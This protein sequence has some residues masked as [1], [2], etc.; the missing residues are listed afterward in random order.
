MGY[1]VQADALRGS[2]E[3]GRKSNRWWTYI[4]WYLI[5]TGS[6]NAFILYNLSRKQI[7]KPPV[8]H[9]DFLKD[10]KL[11]SSELQG[12]SSTIAESAMGIDAGCR[13]TKH[14]HSQK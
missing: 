7:G 4:F 1:V 6:V 9:L 13:L 12:E 11:R 2:Y 3:M 10:R 5:N 8:L 14:K